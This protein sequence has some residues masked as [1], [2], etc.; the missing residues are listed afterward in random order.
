MNIPK[1]K[2]HSRKTSLSGFTLVELIVVITI[3]SILWLIAMSSFQWY[4]AGSRDADRQSTLKQLETWLE[5]HKTRIWSYPRPDEI[6]GTWIINGIS[7]SLLW[8]VWDPVSRITNLNKIPVDP[9]TKDRYVYATDTSGK[10]YQVAIELEKVQANYGIVIPQ[11]YAT[12][13]SQANIIWTY[14]WYLKYNSGSENWVTNIPSLIWNNTWSNIE[15]TSSGTYYVLNQWDNFLGIISNDNEIQNVNGEELI[16]RIRN[17]V[18]TKLIS[19]LY[20]DFVSLI[21]TGSVTWKK[22]YAFATGIILP[23]F[24][25]DSIRKVVSA[26]KILNPSYIFSDQIIPPLLLYKISVWNEHACWINATNKLYCWGRNTGWSLWDGTAIQ[27][28][29]PTAIDSTN[30]Y[31]QVS[32]WWDNTCWTRSDGKLYCWWVNTYWQLWDGT[33]TS[34]NIPTTIDSANTYIQVSAWQS[35][36]CWIRSDNKLYCWGY[37]YY[38]QL[39]DSTTTQRTTPTAIDSTNTYTQVS[40]WQN[41]TC[42]IRS[43]GKLYCWW[44]N[45]SW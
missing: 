14:P 23:S 4:I 20:E 40:V 31:T 10:Y 28:S 29:S 37:N 25:E 13:T 45:T 7:L 11:T 42:W 26:E 1:I 12:T 34:T 3:L 41:H 17:N 19:V 5:I 8:Y 32:A 30:T 18:D 38:G 36:T 27:R 22:S 9:L 24:G 6:S 44:K 33:T 15:L 43:D 16:H 39:W 2:K 35:H 21:Q